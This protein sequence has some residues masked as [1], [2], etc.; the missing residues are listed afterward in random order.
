[1][2]L[3]LH[4]D[5]DVLCTIARVANWESTLFDFDLDGL[6]PD[7]G[8]KVETILFHARRLTDHATT[9]WLVENVGLGAEYGPAHGWDGGHA[10]AWPPPD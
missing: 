2:Q 3:W 1:V 9:L 5:V 7:E 10:P 8:G 4:G 6:T